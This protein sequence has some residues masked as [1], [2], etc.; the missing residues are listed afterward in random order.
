MAQE[1]PYRKEYSLRAVGNKEANTAVSIPPAVIRR[2]AEKRG[3]T[4]DEFREK[5]NAIAEFNSFEGV[6]YTFKEK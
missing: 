5:F 1:I 6:H 3:L 2:E 4:V